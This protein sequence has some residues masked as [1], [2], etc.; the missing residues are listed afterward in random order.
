M[1]PTTVRKVKI[2]GLFAVALLLSPAT[3][4]ADAGVPILPAAYPLILLFLVPVIA[5]EV[6]YIQRRLRTQW[7][8]TIIATT[9]ANT[10]TMLLGYPLI[11]ILLVSLQFQST[12]FL[13]QTHSA[14]F[15]MIL[16][17]AWPTPGYGAD[18]E[19]LAAFVIL[20]VPAFLLSA[21]V[22]G[23]LLSRFRWPRSDRRSTHT[24]WVANVLSYCFLAIA[25]CIVVWWRIKHP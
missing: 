4:Y 22:E 12:D 24:V 19:I 25:G 3:A 6:F 20:L 14:V 1:A 10:L 18:W 15:I 11:W 17:A 5:I 2:L 13:N 8:N 21:F 23:I 16:T 9:I 7:R